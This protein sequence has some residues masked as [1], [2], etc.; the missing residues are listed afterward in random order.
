MKVFCPYIGLLWKKHLISLYKEIFR[1]SIH[2]CAAFVPFF[3]ARFY[4]ATMTLLVL[5]GVGYTLCQILALRGI[6]IPL[7]SDITD[8]AARAR[9]KGKFVL[10]PLTL[11]IGI[12]LSALLWEQKAA[13]AG[14]LALAFGDGLA[15][16]A[17]KIFGNL[18]IPHT[19]GKTCAGSLV[20]FLAIFIS[21]FCVLQN[22]EAA[23]CLAVSGMLIE[24]LPLK[25]FDN[26]LIP[27]A[28]GAI[29]HFF[30]M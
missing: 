25:D 28:L 17:G 15:S 6:S 21:T 19:G 5:A 9:D 22:A 12:F 26:I 23:L 8:M 13:A 27:V 2:L 24:I 3:L 11:V 4:G 7:I 10:G 30:Y 29:V 16:L 20:C 14:I 1:K 18:H